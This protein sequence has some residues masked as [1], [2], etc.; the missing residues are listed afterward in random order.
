MIDAFVILTPILLL[1]V[2]ALLGFVGCNQVF[3]IKETGLAMTVTGVSPASGPTQG[4]QQVVVTGSSFAS[5]PKVTF[6]G[7]AATV[8]NAASGIIVVQTP[9]H[10]SGAVD[11]VVTNP[12]GNTGT[13]ASTDLLHYTYAAVANLGSVI[14]P[15]QSV[16]TAQAS[17]AFSG[18]PKLIVATVLYETGTTASLAVTGGTFGPAIKSDLWSSYK[19]ETFFAAMVPPG[20][21]VVVTA[22][23]SGPTVNFWYLCVTVYDNADQT[24]PIYAPNSLNSINTSTFTPVTVQAQD[25]SDLIYSL[26]VA[27]TAGGSFINVGSLSAG[28]GFQS[29]SDSGF[30]LIQDQQTA[31]AGLVSATAGTTGTNTGRWYLLA[32]GIKHT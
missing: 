32:M 9:P 1:G 29:E 28:A 3:G 2:I 4:G 13:L 12:D 17:V 5:N 21:N 31:A 27:Q 26:A 23:L 19:V 15:G 10:G 6:G 20:P 8:T 25:A 24:T 30:L 11:V 18:S 22:T 14:V 16:G 7:A